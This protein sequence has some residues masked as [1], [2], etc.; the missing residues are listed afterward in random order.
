MSEIELA[1]R[2]ASASDSEPPLV[3]IEGLSRV[4]DLSKRWLNRVLEGG[5]KVILTAVDDVDLSIGRGETYALVGKS[6]SGKSTIAK[7]AV[8]L[9]V[10]SR[11]RRRHRRR[12]YLVR[13]R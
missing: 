9:L 4:F 6:G 8:G 13:A 1:P 7:L 11:W 10:P 3:R 5:G 2:A 12:R